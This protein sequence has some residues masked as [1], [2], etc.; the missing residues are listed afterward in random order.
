MVSRFSFFRPNVI[1]SVHVISGREATVRSG[2]CRFLVR[3]PTV[4]QESF[5][6][7]DGKL[8][9][10]RGAFDPAR[11]PDGTPACIPAR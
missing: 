4:G 11:V 3:F 10:T 6:A 1:V 5:A 2:R 8:R 7:L 9:C